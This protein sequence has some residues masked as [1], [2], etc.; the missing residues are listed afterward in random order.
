[1]LLHGN[2]RDWAI[3]EDK[4]MPFDAALR[5]TLRAADVGCIAVYE[6]WLG[7]LFGPEDQL[8]YEAVLE[9]TADPTRGLV[10]PPK[11]SGPLYHDPSQALLS[12][13]LALGAES[14]RVAAVI[15]HADKLFAADQFQVAHERELAIL[16]AQAMARA[17]EKPAWRPNILVLVAAAI[18]QVP[19]W[20]YRD[21]PHM[22][23]IPVERPDSDAREVYFRTQYG[24]FLGEH[25]RTA[26][27][28]PPPADVDLFARCTDG[29]AFAEL[30]ALRRA[31]LSARVPVTD[32][33][34]LVDWFKYPKRKDPWRSSRFDERAARTKLTE[35]VIGQ[36]R[37]VQAV[38]DVLACASGGIGL[39]PP[40][41]TRPKGVL[42]FV[43][44]TGVGKTE[45]AKAV[46]ELVFGDP[47][48]FIRFDMSEYAL[49]H[50]ALRLTGAPP[51]YLGHEAGGQ[52]TNRMKLRPFSLLLFD[53]VD[54]AHPRVLD[55]LLQVLDD[56]R[57]TDGL[58]ETVHFGKCLIIFTSN[59]GSVRTI[60][61]DG[62]EIHEPAIPAAGMDDEA[63]VV[64]HYQSAV[65][66]EFI[67]IGR[68]ELL[69]RIGEENIVVFGFI[70]AGD[71]A[72]ILQKFRLSVELAAG[73]RGVQ[74][75][76]DPSVTAL[77]ERTMTNEH[78]RRLGARSIR[79]FV[80]RELLPPIN[81]AV[82]A[83]GERLLIRV[84][85]DRVVAE[86]RG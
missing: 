50:D 81:R 85:D 76:W 31:S 32:V 12:F 67:R 79:N 30:E 80:Q 3:V 34:H 75:A 83:G 49:E 1:M 26:Q 63:A 42:F 46:T 52:L 19:A 69:G 5:H 48:A 15:T 27:G 56:G 72:T 9:K 35:R 57:L 86:Q 14:P 59:C 28:Q 61:R 25:G 38:L 17:Y 68:P 62:V 21:N 41:S 22:A 24:N 40:R 66:G 74:L 82:A 37:A 4:L 8:K 36:P 10:L 78:H 7:L 11:T 65:R 20:L 45:M 77:M 16:L 6:P 60:Q 54:K 64:E 44:P 13:R 43:G 58:G 84:Q 53:E 2:V 23:V 33:Q 71:V 47:N 73:E 55:K 39:E 29:M 70:K 18:G 51:S